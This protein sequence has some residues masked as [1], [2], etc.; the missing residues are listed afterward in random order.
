MSEVR[1]AE[2]PA[3]ATRR[4]RRVS[5]A[6]ALCVLVMAVMTVVALLGDAVAPTDPSSQDVFAGLTKPSAAHW[7]GTDEL[8]RDVFSRLIAGTRAALLGPAVIALGSFLVGNVLGLIAGYY[9]GTSDSIVMR[10]VDLMLA[11]PA[12]LVVIV[13]SGATGGGYWVAVGLLLALTIPFD[14][15]VVRGATLE[16]TPLPYVEAA[17][18]LGISSRRIMLLHIWPNVSA[19]AVANTFLVFTVSLISLSGLSYL[20]LGSSPGSADWGLML[21][22]G[23]QYLFLNPVATLV[24]ALLIIIA[25]VAMNLLGDWLQERLS[26]RGATR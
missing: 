9:G 7:L 15:R 1:A 17:K 23:Q 13:V 2:I 24:P 20:G 3:V 19:T 22:E 11:I 5:P 25:A 6:I 14:T 21:A 18:T 4:T 10:W 16:Q 8:G 26:T 12:L